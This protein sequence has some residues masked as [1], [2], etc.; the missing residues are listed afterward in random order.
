MIKQKEML[1]QSYILLKASG[2]CPD[3]TIQDWA[4]TLSYLHVK[5]WLWVHFKDPQREIVDVVAAAYR[6]IGH[7]PKKTDIF[8][9]EEKGNKL[10]VPFAASAASD[11]R[12]L[13][14]MLDNLV[15]LHDKKGNTIREIIFYDWN[16]ENK[17]KRF[18]RKAAEKGKKK[19]E[20]HG[21]KEN[22]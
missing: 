7:N 22:T 6:V 1:R 16:N 9:K 3:N 5:G 10:Y 19:K 18:K 12:T 15:K 14:K 21:K 11:H 20:K 17:L 13:K 4:R 2:V 8:P